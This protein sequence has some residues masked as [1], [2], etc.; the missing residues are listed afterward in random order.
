MYIIY[1]TEFESQSNE[2]IARGVSRATSFGE[3][4]YLAQHFHCSTTCHLADTAAQTS[5]R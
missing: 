2:Q 4:R 5:P 1:R 3:T